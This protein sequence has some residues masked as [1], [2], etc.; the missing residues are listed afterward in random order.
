MVQVILPSSF[1]QVQSYRFFQL[2]RQVMLSTF[3]DSDNLQKNLSL[4]LLLQNQSLSN[5]YYDLP[6]ET[7]KFYLSFSP[8]IYFPYPNSSPLH[9]KKYHVCYTPVCSTSLL[10]W[11]GFLLLQAQGDQNQRELLKNSS[12]MY[13]L[14]YIPIICLGKVMGTCLIRAYVY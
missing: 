10:K 3:S 14:L 8:T 9:T 11:R 5:W 4:H 1:Q 12:D 6:E 7:S 13:V 2:N